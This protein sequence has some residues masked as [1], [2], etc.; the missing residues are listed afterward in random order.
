MAWNGPRSLRQG[1]QAE[2]AGVL[3]PELQGGRSAGFASH[4]GEGI[5]VAQFVE[6]PT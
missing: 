3:A 1:V 4:L 5:M 6:A 2:K